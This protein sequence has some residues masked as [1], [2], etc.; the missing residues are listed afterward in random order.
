MNAAKPL[1]VYVQG[2]VSSAHTRRILEGL[3]EYAHAL[4]R[5]WVV[6][7]GLH[8]PALPSLHRQGFGGI[9]LFN[10]PP[11][12][13]PEL[14]R[15]RLAIVRVSSVSP[16]RGLAHV[17]PDNRAIGELAARHFLDRHYTHF[18]YVG[19]DDHDYSRDRLAG[20]AGAL[21]GHKVRR[22]SCNRS[23]DPRLPGFVAKLPE[24]T[25]I[26]TAND[27]FARNVAETMDR[28]GL[29]IPEDR[30]LVG[31]DNDPLVSLSTNVALSSIDPNS[32][33]IGRRAGAMLAQL[34][35]GAPRLAQTERV[36]PAG[37]V[38]R[39]SSD[40]LATTDDLVNRAVRI[41]RREACNGLSVTGLCGQL[42]IGRRVFE[43]RFRAVLGKTIEAEMRRERLERAKELLLSTALPTERVAEQSGFSDPFYFS[44]AFRKATGLS[45][46]AWRNSFAQS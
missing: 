28:L 3:A 44:A 10:L 27:I 9:V 5:P 40:Q 15:S 19:C 7:W 37:V 14:R 34:M 20:F 18:A 46:R 26:F 13:L 17:I 43:R 25:A 23:P 11:E 21:P 22:F 1:M 24:R 32:M 30:S 35:A 12:R 36:P 8:L 33:E 29:R 38:L 39:A 6:R 16:A 4:P 2:D 42:G 31:V 41:I 45:P